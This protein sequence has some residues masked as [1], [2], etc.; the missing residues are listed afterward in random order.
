M[1]EEN[2]K[3][4]GRREFFKEAAKRVLPIIGAVALMSNPVIA[5]AVE[6]EHMDCNGYG[7]M[8]SCSGAC[9][10]ACTGCSG[11]CKNTCSYACDSTC[12]GSCQ[13]SCQG[14]CQY[15][16]STSCGSSSYY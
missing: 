4:E 3:L 11:T 12:K 7:C 10:D 2:K 13:G 15:S 8:Y 1:K 16:C 9:R 6:K 5:K 14:R